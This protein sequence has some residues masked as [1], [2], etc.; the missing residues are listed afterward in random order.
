VWGEIPLLGIKFVVFLDLVVDGLAVSV[1]DAVV[2]DLHVVAREV[3]LDITRQAAFAQLFL[4]IFIKLKN[5]QTNNARQWI[6]IFDA[7]V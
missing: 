4:H 2:D 3:L 7:E 1:D 5:T 6:L